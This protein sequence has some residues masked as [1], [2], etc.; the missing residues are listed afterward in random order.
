MESYLSDNADYMVGT[1]GSVVRW[2]LEKKNPTERINEPIKPI[3]FYVDP[4]TPEKWRP[5]IRKGIEAWQPAFEAA[6][7][8]NAIIAKDPPLDDPTWSVDDIRNSVVRWPPR[9]QRDTSARGGTANTI[10]DLR[11]G[12]I[13]KA[14]AYVPEAHDVLLTDWYFTMMAPLDP[15]AQKLPFPDSLMG[16]L[17][18]F[19]TSHEIGHALGLKDGSYGRL[20]YPVDSL[21]SAA[22]LRRMGH[23][24]SIMNYARFNYVAQPEDS[25]PQ[26]LLI[27]SVGPADVYSIQWGYT[28]IPG[29]RTP[30]DEKPILDAWARVQDTVPW[31]RFILGRPE[32]EEAYAISEASDDAD[33]IRSTELG[34]KN[35]RRVMEILPSA[36]VYP[37]SDNG[38]LEH[39]YNAT[40][41]QWHTE[42][43]RVIA[44]IGGFHV[45]Y[46][47]G[48]QSGPVYTPVRAA[49]QRAAMKFLDRAAF[50][51][52]QWL[53]VPE[54]A[55]RV[56]PTD[57][58]SRVVAQQTAVLAEL[59]NT[60]RLE[61]MRDLESAA[62]KSEDVYSI[63]E[64][65]GDLRRS[66]WSE[67]ARPRVDIDPY[68][69][70]LQQ[71]H[72]LLLVSSIKAVRDAN[73]NPSD[74]EYRAT[75]PFLTP[76]S[77][78]ALEAQTL[79]RE[80]ATAIPRAAD[81]VTLAHLTMMRRMI[82]AVLA[83][84]K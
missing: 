71:T 72:L 28:P 26:D 80:I 6:G 1:R 37:G 56:M 11:T 60:K 48:S 39:L 4:L 15:R 35:L 24:P 51:V 61:R 59:L 17:Y 36:A 25:I 18:Q 77:L 31:M 63:G 82:D 16:E 7:F 70:E 74:V 14:N 57:I 75:A 34:V 33:P 5:Y 12:E 47:L 13:L 76:H 45:Q 79:R 32:T 2:R 67:L 62:R 9:A 81:R 65:F 54:I 73:V 23:S 64:L 66:L 41:R 55:H 19:V 29:A 78:A 43:K 50:R 20:A 46:K 44:M 42:V 8:R 21:R 22:W 53:L 52:P 84:E 49:E 69:Q 68:R 27:R 38:L 58:G 10:V 40:L 3:V 30:E 83:E